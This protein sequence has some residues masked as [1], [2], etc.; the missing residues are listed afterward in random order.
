[1]NSIKQEKIINARRNI[2]QTAIKLLEQGTI[3]LLGEE[4]TS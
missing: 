2:A 1:M 3:N 4:G